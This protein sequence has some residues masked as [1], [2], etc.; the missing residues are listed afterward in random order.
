MRD[1]IPE[2]NIQVGVQYVVKALLRPAFSFKHRRAIITVTAARAP[3]V[4]LGLPP[5]RTAALPQVGVA[6]WLLLPRGRDGSGRGR[7]GSGRGRDGSGRGRDGSGRSASGPDMRFRDCRNPNPVMASAVELDCPHGRQT[8]QHLG[9]R[10]NGA[11]QQPRHRG[12]TPAIPLRNSPRCHT[13]PPVGTALQDE[14][15][16]RQAVQC[17]GLAPPVLRHEARRG[18][19]LVLRCPPRTRHRLA[20]PQQCGEVLLVEQS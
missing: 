13:H 10:R 3:K 16:H 9:G 7:D 18:R 11:A 20:Q 8:A 15:H 4:G 17:P 6:R 5:H 14:E 12:I 19:R 1:L 2:C